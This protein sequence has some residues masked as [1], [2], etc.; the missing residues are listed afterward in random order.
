MNQNLFS[1]V[2]WK[3]RLR[4]IS[5]LFFAFAWELVARRV[6]SL[7]FPSFTDTV[8]AL[9]Q[10][11]TTPPLWEALWI[12]NQGMVLG[13]SLAAATGV[14]LGFLM[15]RQ[16]T[17]EKFLDP[18]LNILLATPMSALI[19]IIIMA[20]GLGLVSRVLIIFSFAVV[21]IVVNTRAGVRSVDGNWIEMARALGATEWQ[22]WT[23]ILLRGALPALLT[24]LRLGLTRSVSGMIVVEL[25]LLALGLG[26]LIL[27]FQGGFESASLYATV[28][29]VV[30]EAVALMQVFRRLERRA[31]PWAGD[32][33]V[34]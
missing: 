19:P 11:I 2:S 28:F 12:S 22:I 21:V 5:L 23:K 14:P 10:L 25:L 7:L 15:G 26:R 9:G 29:V 4:L 27:D 3:W 8:A 17:A 13:F 6:G 30:L 31:T 1:I 20:T 16:R 24:G 18:Y 33:V 34:E 32:I